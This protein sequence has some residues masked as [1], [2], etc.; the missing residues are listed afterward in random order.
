[1]LVFLWTPPHFW[2]L[3]IV[4]RNDYARAGVPMLPVVRGEA[5]TRWQVFLYT[6]ELVV[7]TLLFPLLGLGGALYAVLAAVLGLW[8]LGAAYRVWKGSGNKVAWKMYRYSSMYLAF[9]FFA[10]MADRLLF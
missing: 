5:E 2:A 3:A 8:L 4:R 10:L 9:I 6:V 1:M 7:V